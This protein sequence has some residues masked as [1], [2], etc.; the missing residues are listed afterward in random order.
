MTI[1]DQKS[2][3]RDWAQ[4]LSFTI[5]QFC[6]AYHISQPHYY[7]LKKA[8]KAP[9][10]LRI[11]RRVVIPRKSADEWEARMLAEQSGAAA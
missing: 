6:A 1:D 4:D 10:E 7:S 2:G 11:G 5:P 9:R 3:S 8:G